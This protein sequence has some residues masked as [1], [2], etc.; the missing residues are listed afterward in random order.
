M[1]GT[2]KWEARTIGSV[3]FG[4][5]P[6]RFGNV[7]FLFN[8]QTGNASLQYHAV[9]DDELTTIKCIDSGEE[10]P[11]RCKLVEDSSEKLIDEQYNLART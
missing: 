4:Y 1:T 3:Y 6:S 2:P 5:S 10:P 8:I 7:A 11:T 9:Y